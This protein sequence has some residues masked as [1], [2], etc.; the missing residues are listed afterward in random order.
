MGR[1]NGKNHSTSK[2]GAYMVTPESWAHSR[3]RDSREGRNGVEVFSHVDLQEVPVDGDGQYV[4]PEYRYL[5][6]VK[7]PIFGK[8]DCNRLKVPVPPASIVD[9]AMDDIETYPLEPRISKVSTIIIRSTIPSIAVVGFFDQ[10]T[11]NCLVEYKKLLVRSIFGKNKAVEAGRSQWSP[12]LQLA[13]FP[14]PNL[15]RK[16]TI[17]KL[18]NVQALEYLSFVLTVPKRENVVDNRNF[19]NVS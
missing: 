15:D 4:V 14:E 12:F 5:K 18:P 3:L 11:Q 19:T 10:K 1:K 17:A 8:K 2:P 7:A 16:A 6:G 9:E 13:I